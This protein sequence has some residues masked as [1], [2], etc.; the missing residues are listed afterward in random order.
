MSI[1]PI[2]N[3]VDECTNYIVVGRDVTLKIEKEIELQRL[4]AVTYQQNDKLFD[5]AHLISYNIRSN[6]NNIAMIVNIIENIKD[7]D[8]KLSCF[9]LFKESIN[10][11]CATIEHL[12]EIITI[13]NDRN[14]E[15]KEINLKKVIENTKKALSKSIK[16]SELMV[17]D[18]IPEDLI[19][20]AIPVY[21][22]S[23]LL[24]LFV[25]AIKYRVIGQRPILEIGYEINET[26]TIITF[27]DNGL[28]IDLKK[29]GHKLFGMYKTFHGNIDAK[30]IGLFIVKNQM[31]AMNGK[32]EVESE[33]GIGSVFKIYLNEK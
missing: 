28:G 4:L 18:R 22:D 10:K 7:P 31:E 1:S 30:G 12:S 19:V 5:L 13:Q 32:I 15:K 6:T 33:V 20:S 2:F 27:K 14:I 24:N 17:I 25:N 16:G 21:L 9:S 8:Q 26:Y 11:L 23:I 29:Y 3:Q